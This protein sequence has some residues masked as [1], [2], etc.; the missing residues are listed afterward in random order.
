MEPTELFESV[1]TDLDDNFMLPKFFNIRSIVSAF[2]T[3]AEN[4]G[5]SYRITY[6]YNISLITV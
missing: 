1:R 6:Y 4:Q 3:I 5:A 2:S